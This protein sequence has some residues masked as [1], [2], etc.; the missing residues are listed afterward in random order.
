MCIRIL[1]VRRVM[2]DVDMC[3]NIL[4]PSRRLVFQCLC[5]P[6][7]CG[8]VDTAAAANTAHSCRV[9]F[10]YLKPESAECSR[11]SNAIAHHTTEV[12]VI[13]DRAGLSMEVEHVLLSDNRV[14]LAVMPGMKRAI[15][16]GRVMIR[17]SAAIG[18][19]NNGGAF[20]APAVSC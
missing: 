18:F 6:G 2:C 12:G 15:D 3:G 20:Q 9:G 11:I 4:L 13:Y 10:V 16:S 7:A 8:A 14:G 5:R 1:Q 17:Q 19:S